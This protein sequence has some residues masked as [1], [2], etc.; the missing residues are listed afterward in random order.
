[1]ERWREDSGNAALMGRELPPDEVLAA[2]ERIA[3]WARRAAQGRGLDGGM[4]ELRARAYLDLLLGK[5]SRPGG[6]PARARQPGA[7]SGGFAGRVTL[8]APLATLARLADRPGELSGLGPVDPWLTR[9]LATAAARNPKTTW[10]VTSPTTR[11][12]PSGT[13]APGPNPR[14]TGN[15]PD[16]AAAGPARVLLHP[17]QPGRPARRVR[18]LAA[19]HPRTR[20]RP[21]HDA[22]PDHHRPLRPPIPG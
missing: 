11:G 16:P 22:R 4:D 6:S 18:H 8:T 5:D 19:A 21:D 14:A 12:T 10:C 3:W 7:A 1:M 15:A 2:E 13:A 17:G 9:D 20:A